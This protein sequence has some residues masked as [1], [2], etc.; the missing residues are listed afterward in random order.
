MERYPSSDEVKIIG[1]ILIET[2]LKFVKQKRI[3]YR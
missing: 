3:E 2:L 1:E